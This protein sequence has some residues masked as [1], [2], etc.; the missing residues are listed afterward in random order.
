MLANYNEYFEPHG[1]TN[2]LFTYSNSFLEKIL[3]DEVEYYES[4]Y[5]DKDFTLV[6]NLNE[7]YENQSDNNERRVI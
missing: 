3:N 5:L 7:L 6:D 4:E 1:K 2:K